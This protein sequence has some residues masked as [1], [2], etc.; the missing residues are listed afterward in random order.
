VGSNW[1]DC[2]EG[3]K[4]CVRER[5]GEEVETFFRVGAF[6]ANWERTRSSER[7][8]SSRR[9]KGKGVNAKTI[10]ELC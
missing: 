5:D 3:G 8:A 6:S 1:L 7:G 4:T 10:D 2:S 9:G